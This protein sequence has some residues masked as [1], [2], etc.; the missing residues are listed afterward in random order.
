M[1]DITYLPVR[2]GT[3]LYLATVLDCY[4][5]RLV[6]FSIADHMRTELAQDALKAAKNLRGGLG[7]AIFH[8]DHG[9]VYTCKSYKNLCSRLRVTQSMGAVGTSADNAFAESF[10]STMKREVLQARQVFPVGAGSQI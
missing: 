5:G 9:S 10:N 8:S 1:G 6:G 7:G 3:N 4:S 2:G